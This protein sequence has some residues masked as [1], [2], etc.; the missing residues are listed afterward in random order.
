MTG[1]VTIRLTYAA[2]NDTELIAA[3]PADGCRFSAVI[4][5]PLTAPA[6]YRGTPR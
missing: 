6:T 5:V 2:D 4:I 3:T 1:N